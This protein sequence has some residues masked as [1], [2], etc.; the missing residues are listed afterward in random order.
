MSGSTAHRHIVQFYE[1]EAFLIE[2]L[3]E[4]LIPGLELG[5][6]GL[7]IAAPERRQALVRALAGAGMRPESLEMKGL[8]VLLDARETLDRFLV[9][10]R[11]DEARFRK[12]FDGLV[13]RAH[14]KPIRAFGEMVALLWAEGREEAA[15]QLEDLWEAALARS[16]TS[17]TPEA[18][19][20]PTTTM[21]GTPIS[22]ASANLTPGETSRS[23][24]MT[25]TPASSS[26]A[27]MRS[28]VWI[29]SAACGPLPAITRCTSA[30]ATSRG[31]TRPFSSW[32]FSA[33][34]ATARD[35]PTP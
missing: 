21:V 34:A 25:C 29:M 33:M 13:E 30:G 7:V 26:S 20:R 14:G 24:R 35:T 1:N 4:Y 3:A 6:M 5:E 12:V 28:A 15:V 10:D 16:R 17:T 27:A 2:K 18:R 11:L 8:L 32:V 9:E 23:S 22:S 31:Q 19:P